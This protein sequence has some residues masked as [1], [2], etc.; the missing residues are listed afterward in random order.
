MADQDNLKPATDIDSNV[1]YQIT[2][3]DVD[4]YDGAFKSML[5]TWDDGG[6]RV[7]PVAN[8]TTYWQFVRGVQGQGAK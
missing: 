2:E 4:D 5:Q 8:R 7:F 1:W 6:F 3:E